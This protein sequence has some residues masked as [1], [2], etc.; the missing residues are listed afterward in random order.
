MKIETLQ[1]AQAIY[2]QIQ[3]LEEKLTWW[4]RSTHFHPMESVAKLMDANFNYIASADVSLDKFY[5]YIKAEN[6]R[7]IREALAK[8]YVLFT[9]LN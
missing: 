9:E 1:E 6:I 7:S 5:Q 3:L 8:L 4:E 2:Q